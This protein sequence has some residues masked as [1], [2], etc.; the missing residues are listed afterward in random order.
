MSSEKSKLFK[1]RLFRTHVS[2]GISFSL[3]MYI[4]L[5]F[6]IFAIFLP[7]IQV[8]EK[9]SRHIKTIE[10]TEINYEKMLNEVLKDPN[11][12]R[13]KIQIQLPGFRN[14]PALVISH[15]F[16]EKFLF[17]PLKEKKLEHEDK[18]SNLAMFLNG[19]HYGRPL[20]M[21]GLYAFGLVAVAVLFLIIGGLIFVYIFKFNNKS[22]NQQSTFSK[23]HRKIFIWAFPIF[24]LIVLCGAVMGV[25]F[26]STKSVIYI[27]TKGEKS[28]IRPLIGPVLFPL[29]KT[30]KLENKKITSM[31]IK[32]LIKIAKK[33]NPDI[34]YEKLTLINWG[35]ETARIKIEGYNPFKPFL[36]GVTNK[37]NIV[38]R[39]KD[40]K[41]LEHN[42]VENSSW[43]ILATD[44]VYFLHLLFGVDLITRILVALVMLASTFAVGF[45]VM[46]WL[47][48]KAKKFEGKITFY[49]WKGKLSLA[50]ILGV[51]PSTA[52]LFNLQW[53]LPFDLEDRLIWQHGIFYNVWLFTLF[54]SFYKINS[55]KA[56]KEFLSI[57]G[58][59]FIMS[60]FLH[61][62][63][64]GFSPSDLI[65]NSLYNILSVD[66][67][68]ILLGSILLI[69]SYK[70]P[71][72]RKEAKIFW[73]RNKK[74][75][76]E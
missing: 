37:P 47:E 41:L 21:I 12:P 22:K 15:Q 52:V 20:K 54:W 1:Q 2:V 72:N 30:I 19:L 26:D 32:D 11:F 64:S 74:D 6:G 56:S 49:H 53:L 68:L 39:V 38:L 59:L 66:I 18:V 65:E 5:F 3:L 45:G 28:N 61:F 16:S 34:N 75:K 25:G 55:Y 36:N 50:V 58:I 73:T 44:F 8:W 27:A 42:K 7:Y 17:D 29:E 33:I 57:G 69:V 24:F 71:K 60:S 13:D 9:P 62:Y 40:G 10:L 4:A 14:D 46:L 70:L 43:P 63:K 76:N 31:Q 23:W 51:I 48:K 35:D 67:T